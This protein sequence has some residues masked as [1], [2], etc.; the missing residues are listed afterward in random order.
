MTWY[1]VPGEP[2]V[3]Y[4]VDNSTIGGVGYQS[5][6]DTVRQDARPK[7]EF[8]PGFHGAAPGPSHD[9]NYRPRIRVRA[10]SSRN[11]E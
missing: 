2:A 3:E 5:T 6:L 1:Q 7:R 10:G 4:Y 11:R 8:P 9:D